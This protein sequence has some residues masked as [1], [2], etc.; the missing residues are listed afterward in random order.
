MAIVINEFEAVAEAPPPRPRAQESSEG[1]R[2]ASPLVE[3]RDV[4]P[5]L[6]LLAYQTLRLWAH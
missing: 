3:A 4:G 1:E 2:S 6:H 5:V